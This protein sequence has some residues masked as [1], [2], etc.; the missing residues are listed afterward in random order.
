MTDL[1][2]AIIT[3]AGDR[4]AMSDEL[5][6]AAAD[7]GE[8]AHLGH[9]RANAVR[10]LVLPPHARVLEVGAGFGALTRHLGE[11][12]ASVVAVEPDPARADAA[13]LRTAG[14]PGV[15]VREDLPGSGAFDLAVVAAEH[16]TP[17]VLTAL[18][19]RVA[20]PVCVLAPDRAAAAEA[21][22]ALGVSGVPI[23]RELVC[24]PGTDAARAVVAAELAAEQPRLRA[25]LTRCGAAGVLLLCGDGA[26]ELWPDDRLATYFNTA[27]RAA[28][29][30]TRADVVRAPGG[31]V[32]VRRTPLT[33]GPRRVA[34]IGIRSWT[35]TVRDAPTLDEV[36]IEQPWRAAELLG[37]WRALLT[38]LAPE[39]GPGL[40]DLLPHNVLV[41]ADGGVHPI[42][43]EWEHHGAEVSDVLERGLLVLAHQLAEAGWRGA[44]EGS[45]AREL[46]GWL[47]V[48]IGA[49]PGFVDAA[50]E[51]E[52]RFA[53][54]AS[55]G[56]EVGTDAVADAVRAVWRARVEAKVRAA[57]CA[58]SAGS[59]AGTK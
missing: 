10:A 6:F 29:A 43:L 46:A 11:N 48:A 7:D 9:D 22:A 49:R 8:R 59:A 30:C 23:A 36:L 33:P 13:R 2:A 5:H 25:A 37:R 58:V 12:A 41:D 28:W 1:I 42:D 57:D 56:G 32:E 50:V 52:V 45:T 18:R 20:G 15:E 27:E 47:A 38:D 44:A 21:R 26:G 35:D 54:L 31:T 39:L 19:A 16:A 51:R 14:L 34:E 53:T 3:A 4:S 17:S 24:A 55:C 40:W